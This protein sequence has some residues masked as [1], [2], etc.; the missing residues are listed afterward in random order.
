MTNVQLYD[1]L[2]PV[3]LKVAL[4]RLKLA[5]RYVRHLEEEASKLILWE[6]TQGMSNMGRRAVTYIDTLKR[7]TGIEVTQEL[8][9]KY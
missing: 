3:A 5:G 7:D 6:P 4:R 1:G 8:N 2:P 9:K